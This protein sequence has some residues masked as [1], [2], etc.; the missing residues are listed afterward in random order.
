MPFGR[1]SPSSPDVRRRTSLI[2]VVTG[3]ARGIGRAIAETLA[4]EG[5]SVVATDVDEAGAK[6]TAAAVGGT[7]IAADVSDRALVDAM[8]GR[9]RAEHGR[10]DVLVNNAGIAPAGDFLTQD[11]AIWRQ[12]YEV[13]VIAPMLLAQAAGRHMVDQGGGKIVNIASTTG[14]RGKPGVT[15]YSTSKGAVLRFTGSLAAEWARHNIQ[16]NCI[17]PGAFRTE[18]QKAVTEDEDLL[19]R[20]VRRIPAKRMGDPDE[21]TGVAARNGLTLPDGLEVLAPA[22]HIGR[23]VEPLVELRTKKLRALF[24]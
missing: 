22:E 8:V 5:A 17:A 6:D 4:A 11:P 10:I 20:R 23:F 1:P 15:G 14:V 19:A 18:A 16:V 7:G 12:T 24:K 9:V 13:N 21:I 3:A 2:A